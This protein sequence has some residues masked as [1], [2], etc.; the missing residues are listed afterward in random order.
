MMIAR[1]RFLLSS[2]LTTIEGAK[3]IQVIALEEDDDDDDETIAKPPMNGMH[4]KPPKPPPSTAHC[5]ERDNREQNGQ[6]FKQ[7][8][9]EA[10][11]SPFTDATMSSHLSWEMW[12]N[13]VYNWNGG[14]GTRVDAL[15][16]VRLAHATLIKD[17]ESLEEEPPPSK[18][19]LSRS[20]NGTRNGSPI[21]KESERHKRK[22]KSSVVCFPAPLLNPPDPIINLFIPL[23][24]AHE[25]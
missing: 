8:K 20:A 3:K 6:G 2:E 21:S 15:R 13:L 14:L 17:N 4:D 22:H 9:R 11:P 7:Q 12:F 23:S 16:T 24:N 19:V 10:L 18:T 25:E 5:S 1:K